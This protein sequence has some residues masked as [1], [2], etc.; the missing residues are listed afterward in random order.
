M[1]GKLEVTIYTEAERLKYCL[2]KPINMAVINCEYQFSK[3]CPRYDTCEL[4]KEESGYVNLGRKAGI[5]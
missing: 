1:T 4:I 2:M 3:Q 5:I